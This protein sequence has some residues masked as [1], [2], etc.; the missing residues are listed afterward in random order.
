[1]LPS[2]TAASLTSLG[3]ALGISSLIVLRCFLTS[4]KHLR[5][6]WPNDLM[7]QDGKVAGLLVEASTKGDRLLL[8]IGMGLNL[9]GQAHLST[10]LGRDVAAIAPILKSDALAQDL[11]CQ[12]AMAWQSTLQVIQ[13]QGFAAY[14]KAFNEHDYLAGRDVW[15]SQPERAPIKG[16]AQGLSPDGRLMVMT[17][18]QLRGFDVADVSVRLTMPPT[19]ESDTG[20]Q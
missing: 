6:K 8:V 15:V 10:T 12:L 20:T 13:E 7:L 4:N 2:K 18:S 19:T 5:V 17:D 11:V 16:C 3:P 1:M 9:W 14:H